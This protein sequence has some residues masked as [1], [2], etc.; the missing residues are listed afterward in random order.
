LEQLGAAEED[1]L[2]SEE[3]KEI[4]EAESGWDTNGVTCEA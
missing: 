2:A 3:V 4:S 1:V